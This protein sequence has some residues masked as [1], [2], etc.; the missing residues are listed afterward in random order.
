MLRL[1]VILRRHRG[2]IALFG[3]VSG[4]AS[5]VL[6][7]RQEGF[8]R[9]IPL[10]M[11][12]SWLWLVLENVL[13]HWLDVRFRFRLP[14]P[15][16]RYAT[17]LVHQESLFFVLPFVVL[18]TVWNSAQAL[19]TGA[20]ICAALVSVIDPIYYRWL[21]PRRWL[22]LGFH[23]LALFVVLLTV[24][25]MLLQVPTSHSYVYALLAAVVLS[26]PSLAVAITLRARWRK[27]LLVLLVATLGVVGWHGRFWVPPAALR[28]A[29]MEVALE[30]DRENRAPQDPVREVSTAQLREGGLYAY[31]AINAPLGL[32]ERIYHV[33]VFE[34][35]EVDR[36]ALDIRGGRE[37]GYR[38]W[39]HKRSFP[40]DAAGRW[41]VE[42]VT[43]SGQMVGRLRFQVVEG[44][45][46]A[47]PEVPA[48]PQPEPAPAD[49]SA[50]LLPEPE[51]PGPPDTGA[52][53]VPA[54]E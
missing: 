7:D 35:A 40:R 48:E 54:L 14:A 24:L 30:L 10:V 37:D 1:A 28:L 51:R 52:D 16:L 46:A 23:T 39:T 21:A 50:G 36:I 47:H 32:Q 33:W 49:S 5:F 4:V 12:V 6:V 29:Q 25:P 31:T 27:L 38:A 8:G 11:L 45:A 17:Q 19:F 43:E 34:G 20:L 42:V 41:R 26:F 53:T 18:A 22:Y 9:V 13:Q 15:V 44:P 3:F 2:V